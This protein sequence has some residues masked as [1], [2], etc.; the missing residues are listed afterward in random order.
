MPS[1]RGDGENL[2]SEASVTAWGRAPRAAGEWVP[3]P[4]PAVG[5]CGE[6]RLGG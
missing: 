5:R 3:Y 4:C 6:M 2:A 1:K